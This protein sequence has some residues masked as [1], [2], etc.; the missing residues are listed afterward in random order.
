MRTSVKLR[1]DAAWPEFSFFFLRGWCGVLT[2]TIAESR[3]ETAGL[4]WWTCVL[5]SLAALAIGRDVS[6]D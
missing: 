5:V 2:V 1:V 3:G 6:T 4:Y